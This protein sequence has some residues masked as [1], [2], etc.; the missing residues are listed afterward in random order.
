MIF[1]FLFKKSDFIFKNVDFQNTEYEKSVFISRKSDF[2]RIEF[3][4]SEFIFKK[5]NLKKSDFKKTEFENFYFTFKSYD[6]ESPTSI[7]QVVQIRESNFSFK[8]SDSIFKKSDFIFKKSIFLFK[9]FNF[10]VLFQE[11][12]TRGSLTFSKSASSRRQNS[13]NIPWYW[14]RLNSTSMTSVS[15]SLTSRL[16]AAFSLEVVKC[17]KCNS[18]FELLRS[19]W[20][21]L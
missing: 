8:K 19:F 1:D 18:T 4:K 6:F 21:Q 12:R 7:I 15:R 13:G 14:R 9:K 3:E 11:N 10:E 16:N 17:E 5:A 20:L 2:K